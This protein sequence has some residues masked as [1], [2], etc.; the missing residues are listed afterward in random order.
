MTIQDLVG[1]TTHL[2][3]SNFKL[4]SATREALINE[5]GAGEHP[6]QD[7][8][9]AYSAR[10]LEEL[11]NSFRAESLPQEVRDR[12]K[13]G[14]SLP[15]TF[16]DTMKE[17]LRDLFRMIVSSDDPGQVFPRVVDLIH[18]SLVT[19]VDGLGSLLHVSVNDVEVIMRYL[20]Y[21]NSLNDVGPDF[22]FS[23]ATMFSQNI[24]SR[25][26]HFKAQFLEASRQSSS[27]SSASA[28]A[29]AASSEVHMDIPYDAS[30]LEPMPPVQNLV[31]A[32][33]QR[34]DHDTITVDVPL[35]DVYRSG[36]ISKHA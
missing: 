11:V 20:I 17:P 2:D 9:D 29:A 33:L 21:T 30:L 28:G 6:T 14:A 12:V 32:L 22:A 23:V 26:H 4:I 1:M 10:L 25:Y 35:S 36:S 24:M 5:I 15:D 34:A 27:S 3:S 13:P 7:Q 18:S 19:I 8:V 16:H 31:E